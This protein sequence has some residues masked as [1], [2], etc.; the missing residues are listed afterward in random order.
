MQI[1]VRDLPLYAVPGCLE[2][3]DWMLW[4][5]SPIAVVAAVLAR[6]FLETFF[7]QLSLLVTFR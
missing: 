7:K 1:G 2:D 4:E 3:G 5:I 6:S